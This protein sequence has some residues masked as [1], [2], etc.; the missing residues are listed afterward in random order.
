MPLIH[1]N[2][3][4]AG[5]SQ[6]CNII[7]TFSYLKFCFNQDAHAH[8]QISEILEILSPPPE[9]QEHP[10]T[11]EYNEILIFV[12]VSRILVGRNYREKKG[13]RSAQESF[14]VILVLCHEDFKS[15]EKVRQ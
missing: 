8:A 9:N 12:L 4:G 10:A 13:R 2:D 1:C 7:N 15:F 3:N 6:Y 11:L 14:A 5:I